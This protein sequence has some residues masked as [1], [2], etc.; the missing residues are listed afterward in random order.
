MGLELIVLLAR[1]P[2]CRRK[3]WFG[4]ERPQEE[5]SSNTS[6]PVPGQ[7]KGAVAV[8]PHDREG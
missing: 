6:N 7:E 4:Y 8:E 3:T 2:H 1:G 5:E